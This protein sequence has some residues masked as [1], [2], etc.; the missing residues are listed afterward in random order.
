[1]RAKKSSPSVFTKLDDGTG[2]VLNL[3]TLCYY[4]LNQTGVTLW[5]HIESSEVFTPEDLLRA[6]C[7]RFEVDEDTARVEIGAFVERLQQFKMIRPV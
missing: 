4:S 3:D 2:V 6:T 7:E 5:Q 1:M